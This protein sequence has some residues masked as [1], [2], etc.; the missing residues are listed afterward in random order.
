[1]EN[2]LFNKKDNAKNQSL[3]TNETRKYFD[4]IVNL[5][6]ELKVHADYNE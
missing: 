5:I 4:K 1:M 3:R 6:T 2:D